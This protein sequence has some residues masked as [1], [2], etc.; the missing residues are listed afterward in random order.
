[1]QHS[2]MTGSTVAL[3]LETKAGGLPAGLPAQPGGFSGGEDVART[4]DEFF[5]AF[6]SYR[7]VNDARL[8]E[9]EERGNPDILTLEKLDRL[10][11][12][13]DMTQRRLDQLTLKARRPEIGSEAGARHGRGASSQVLEHRA[14][15]E[16]Y[17][18]TGQEARLRPLELKAMSIGSDADGGYLVPEETEAGILRRLSQVSPIRAIAGNRQVS[19]S[20]YK[21]PY[22]LTGPQT[23]WVGETDARPQTTAPTLAELSFP[24]MELYAMPAASASLL[25]DAAI[26]VDAWI[27]EEVETAFAEQEGA[28]FINGDGVNRPKGFL[29]VDRVAE[30]SWAWG[31]LGTVKSGEAGGFPALSPGDVLLDLIYTLK[32]GYRQNARFVMNRRTQ[33]ALRKL[34]DGDGNYL[35]QPP[36]TA[37]GEATLLN[38]PVTEAEDMPDIAVDAP[39]IAF[40]DFRR[41]YLVVDRMGVRILRDPYSSKPYVLFYTTKRVG[42]GVQ[43]YDAIKLM[44]FSA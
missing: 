13:L 9:I 11:A 29:S 42:G 1:M 32:A 7:E 2:D 24:A 31:K 22:S 41:G 17:V 14:A 33:G 20:T 40:G 6:E 35:W 12:A 21:K 19:A 25:D 34:K 39:A 27:A 10:D 37:G 15:F 38:F 43:D 30:A 36:M 23:G 4:F 18:R 28:A 3:P 8:A 44:T 16:S 5:R 26:D